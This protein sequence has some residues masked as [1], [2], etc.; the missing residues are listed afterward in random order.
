[1]ITINISLSNMMLSTL[2][3]I[4][5]VDIMT[6]K[7]DSESLGIITMNITLSNRMLSTLIFYYSVDIMTNKLDSESLGIITMNCFMEEFYPG[8]IVQE[9]PKTFGIYHYNG[10][11]RSCLDSKVR[12]RW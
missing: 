8:D 12:Y 1:M 6:N 11:P 3:F 2:I 7:I 5:S 9:T 4:Y 10:I